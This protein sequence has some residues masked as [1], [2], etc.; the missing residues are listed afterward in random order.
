MVR[1]SIRI[2]ED[3]MNKTYTVELEGE[4]GDI[5]P[6]PDELCETMGWKVGDTLEFEIEGETILIKKVDQAVR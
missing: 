1:E 2:S 5:L 4:N 3:K 6:I